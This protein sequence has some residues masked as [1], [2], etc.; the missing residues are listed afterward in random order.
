MPNH[1]HTVAVPATEQ[2]LRLGTEEAHRRYSRHVNFREGWRGHLWQG[3]FASFPM[4]EAYLH[5]ARRY[6]ELSPVRARLVSDGLGRDA[7]TLA[8]QEEIVPCARG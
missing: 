3:R 2:A 6:V 7:T 8:G 4:D 1:V 5:A